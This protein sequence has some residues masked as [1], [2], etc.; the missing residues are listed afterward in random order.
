MYKSGKK[1]SI[2][3]II[4]CFRCSSTIENSVISVAMQT[5][6][7][8]ELI[9][10]DDHSADGTLDVLNTLQLKYGQDWIK[11]FSLPTNSGVSFARNFGW[12]N[13]SCEYIA[14]LD[15]D[16][17]WHP[18]KIRLQYN[19]MENNKDVALSGHNCLMSN[20]GREIEFP[21]ANPAFSVRYIKR[22]KLLLSNPFVTPSFMLRRNVKIRFDPSS[23]YAEDYLFLMQLVFS[24]NIIV[25]L[26]VS[27]VCVYKEFGVTGAS[28][29]KFKMRCGDIKNYW[30]LQKL[31]YINFITM[32]FLII[33]SLI[34]YL[35]LLT[36]GPKFYEMLNA[37]LNKSLR[38]I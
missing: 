16:D 20:T 10:V 36:I 9:L 37:Y 22:S 23:R 21:A 5:L 3:V 31:G 32:S 13:S 6:K 17:V 8:A 2:S 25:T 24:G 12:D 35:T 18:E 27:L 1:N 11:I 28:A 26:D 30:L 29:N 15:S 34:K 14:F 4:P 38:R 19:W 7:P 33:Y